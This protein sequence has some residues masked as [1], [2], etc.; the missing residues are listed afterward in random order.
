M[1]KDWWTDWICS[2]LFDSYLFHSY[3]CIRIVPF[4]GISNGDCAVLESEPGRCC[5]W[6]A[7]HRWCRTAPRYVRAPLAP[8][9]DPRQ[10]VC[11][12]TR[13]K[14]PTSPDKQKPGRM[15]LKFLKLNVLDLSMCIW[16]L[17]SSTQFME[18]GC[19]KKEQKESS[20]LHAPRQLIFVLAQLDSTIS[21]RLCMLSTWVYHFQDRDRGRPEEQTL[22]GLQ[23]H[24]ASP[25]G[26]VFCL[27]QRISRHWNQKCISLRLE[28]H[29]IRYLFSKQK[30]KEQQEALQKSQY[31][32]VW[33][34]VIT[35]F[36]SF[37]RTEE[38]LKAPRTVSRRRCK[39]SFLRPGEKVTGY[40]WLWNLFM[41][42]TQ[43][44]N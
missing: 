29:C 4:F 28:K 43:F 37:G 19:A 23:L 38:F 22:P 42:C 34:D 17:W 18:Q 15:Y 33:I 26:C 1:Q 35:N 11:Q 9:A 8:H 7:S 27:D 2:I 31:W 21:S 24:Q 40:G 44:V 41:E 10:K 16:S 25:P 32:G 5:A 6:P 13:E 36:V 39:R 20:C 14:L 3:I 12:K 30:V